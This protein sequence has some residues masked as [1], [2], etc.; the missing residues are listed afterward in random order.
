MNWVFSLIELSM[1]IVTDVTEIRYVQVQATVINAAAMGQ[2]KA[3]STLVYLQVN[4]N[5]VSEST[6]ARPLSSTRIR[7]MN[8]PWWASAAHSF[9]VPTVGTTTTADL[10]S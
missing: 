3:M 1:V 2:D 6:M 10:Q 9:S 7:A 5:N 8:R 4:G